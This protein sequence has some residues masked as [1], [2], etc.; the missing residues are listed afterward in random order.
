MDKFALTKLSYGMYVIGAKDLQNRLCGCIA[1][2]LM[3]ITSEPATVAL[4]INHNNYT[5]ECIKNTKEF[6]VN[7]LPQNIN[8]LIIGTFGFRSARDVDKFANIKY[9]TINNLPVCEEACAYLI[10]KLIST[11]ETNTHTIFLANVENCEI[12]KNEAPMSYDYYHNVIK[13][14][15]PKAAPTYTG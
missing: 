9:K 13:G 5:N 3:Q 12:L 6:S 2:S 1:N 8:P 14:K 10:C 11:L 15:S 7:I 4:S